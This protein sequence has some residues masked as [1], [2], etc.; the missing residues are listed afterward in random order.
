M[1]KNGTPVARY[2][3]DFASFRNFPVRGPAGLVR[4]ASEFPGRFFLTEKQPDNLFSSERS[5]LQCVFLRHESDDS[6]FF[7]VTL[8]LPVVLVFRFI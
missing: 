5:E 2:N 1:K 4:P 7:G 6:G 3:D 8:P